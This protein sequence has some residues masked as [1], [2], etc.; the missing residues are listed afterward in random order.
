MAIELYG[1]NRNLSANESDN[2]NDNVS[3]DLGLTDRHLAQKS[4]Y[5]ITIFIV[6]TIRTTVKVRLVHSST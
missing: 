4:G 6:A 1:N 5:E 2:D 3:T